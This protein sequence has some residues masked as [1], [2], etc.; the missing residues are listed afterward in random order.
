MSMPQFPNGFILLPAQVT[1]KKPSQTEE[2]VYA[3]PPVLLMYLYNRVEGQLVGITPLVAVAL[4][5][6]SSTPVPILT[7]SPSA[8]GVLPALGQRLIRKYSAELGMP[9]AIH[10]KRIEIIF[11][12]VCPTSY[13]GVRI[14]KT[15]ATP[16]NI[17]I[18]D[19]VS[20]QISSIA[21]TQAIS[22]VQRY[23]YEIVRTPVIILKTPEELGD[24][25]RSLEPPGGA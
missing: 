4:A 22:G 20:R 7:N 23:T 21:S 18:R 15:V 11:N 5:F 19:A 13:I 8:Y 17:G 1:Y 24:F 9:N 14:A 2:C 12:P 10:S 3:Y 16:I 25:Y 6:P